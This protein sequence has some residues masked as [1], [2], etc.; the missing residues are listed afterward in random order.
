M[1]TKLLKIFL[2]FVFGIVHSQNNDLIETSDIDNFWNAYD[3]L[4]DA[5][6]INDSINIMQTDY[7]DKS[8]QYFKEFIRVRNF[9]A[10]EYIKLLRKYPKFWISIRK[11]TEN[12]KYRKGEIIKILDKYEQEIPNFKRPNV[13]FGIGC[14]RTG[15]TVSNNLILIG[16]EI[17][18]STRETEKS[19]LSPWLK[20]VIGTNLSL[21]HI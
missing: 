14:L 1:T 20:S 9:K 15:G 10:E 5:K 12:V 7:I 4:K 19:E 3:K 11:E 17:A 21:I 8:S 18:A 6:S 2:L 13:C 16:T